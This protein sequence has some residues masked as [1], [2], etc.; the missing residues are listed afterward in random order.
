MARNAARRMDW[1]RGSKGAQ[2]KGQRDVQPVAHRKDA[3][4]DE[5]L[6]F[7]DSPHQDNLPV[8]P[9]AKSPGI[10]RS[11]QRLLAAHPR[12]S[13][14]GIRGVSLETELRDSILR[15]R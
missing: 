14:K 4:W 12:T 8:Q 15:G 13:F 2:G 1:K 9:V 7:F 5:M 10:E 6:R 11:R 3:T